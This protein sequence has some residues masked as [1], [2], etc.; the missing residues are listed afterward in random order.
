MTERIAGRD[1]TLDALRGVA[2]ILVLT[3]HLTLVGFSPV[4]GSR[5][6]V[7]IQLAV[8]LFY[9]VVTQVAVPSFYLISL[10]LYSRKRVVAGPGYFL[11]RIKRLGA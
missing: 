4:G 3:A 5:A 11:S 6:A 9:K 10:Y 2:I 8:G 7:L 1:G